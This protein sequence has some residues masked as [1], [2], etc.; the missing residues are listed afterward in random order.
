MSKSSKQRKLPFIPKS[1]AF[2]QPGDFWA[3]EYEPGRYT[4]G[5]VIEMP[6]QHGVDDRRTFLA[7]LMDWRSLSLPNSNSLEGSRILAQGKMSVRAFT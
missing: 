5:R 3:M 7:A 2:L 6:W 1:N 4:A